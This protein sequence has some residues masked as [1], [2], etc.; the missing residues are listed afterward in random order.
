ME[1]RSIPTEGYPITREGQPCLPSPFL[2]LQDETRQGWGH[3]LPFAFLAKQ[4]ESKQTGR[5]VAL[6]PSY[7]QLYKKKKGGLMAPPHVVAHLA[8]KK[9]RK[10][11]RR[12]IA[13]PPTHG[14]LS[15]KKKREMQRGVGGPTPIVVHLVKEEKAKAGSAGTP[16]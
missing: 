2:V 16:S 11:T 3:L 8:N 12:G 9:S 6:L 13:P 5:G 14:M 7:E 4:K 10:Q 15:E 1:S